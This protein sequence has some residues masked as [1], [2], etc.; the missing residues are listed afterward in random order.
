MKQGNGHT[1]V[2]RREPFRGESTSLILLRIYPQAKSDVTFRSD[3]FS[4]KK[5][6]N[7]TSY[8]KVMA[9]FPR[10]KVFL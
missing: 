10:H 9:V 3:T 1:H 5:L 8:A 2:N 7:L 4:Y 6:F